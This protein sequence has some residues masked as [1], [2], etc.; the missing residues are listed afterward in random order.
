LEEIRITTGEQDLL[1]AKSFFINN[2][3]F[4]A[5]ATELQSRMARRSLNTEAQII[6]RRGINL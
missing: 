4:H 3:R 5:S 1:R 6:G 2:Q